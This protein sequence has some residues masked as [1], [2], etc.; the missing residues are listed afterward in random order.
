MLIPTT[1]IATLPIIQGLASGSLV[2]YGSVIRHAAGTAQGGQIVAHL[3]EAAGLTSQLATLAIAPPLGAAQIAMNGI[4]H[5]A[6]FNKLVGIDRKIIGL[7][8]TA[9]QILG[10][11]QIAAGASVLGLGVS[12]AGFAYM[13]YKLHQTQKS[14]TQLQQTVNQG[15]TRIEDILGQMSAQLAYIH[16]LLED[17]R[18]QQ[19]RIIDAIAHLHQAFLIREIANL[20]AELENLK[21]FPD[22]SPQA[23]LKVATAARIFL[24]NQATQIQLQPEPNNLLL[25]DIATQ[26]W[27]V[28]TATEAQLL[29][30]HGHIQDAQDLLR[31]T[32]PQLQHH[33]ENWGRTIIHDPRPE[34]NTAQRFATP[35]FKPH[36]TAERV[37]RIIRISPIDQ[38]LGSDRA[39]RKRTE[40]EVELTMS[41]TKPQIDQ[42]WQ[43]RQI[44]LAEYLDTISELTARLDSLLAFADL[45]AAQNVKSST[46]LLPPADA[47]PGLYL[48][49][50]ST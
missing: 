40:A 25:V 23:A 26:G 38:N 7:Q 30:K 42:H 10:V 18:Q 36:I 5:I 13:G 28:A 29:L 27:A 8:Q 22:D 32:V 24:A 12:I 6:T 35:L 34:L 15:F 49:P 45:C 33:A 31:E 3:S 4:G 46:Q 48:L 41:R 17:N 19:Q 2:R 50:A 43:R 1:L 9:A 39:H 11:T 14:I 37:D 16:L 21:R 20:Q 47:Q 44:A